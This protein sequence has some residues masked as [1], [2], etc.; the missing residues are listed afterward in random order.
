MKKLFLLV[1]ALSLMTLGTTPLLAL[2]HPGISQQEEKPKLM[3][4][5]GTVKA[6]GDKITFIADS[7]SKAWNVVNPE[8]L[9]DHV[10]HHVELNAHV[11]ADK[12]E[13]HVMKVKMLG[14]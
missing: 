2:G 7:D 12:G 11:Y 9:R 10:G 14:Q 4:M 6:D 8:T 13:I 5:K 3:D 1:L